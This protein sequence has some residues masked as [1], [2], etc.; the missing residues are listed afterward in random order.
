MKIK[1]EFTQKELSFLEAIAK[2]PYPKNSYSG[3]MSDDKFIIQWK[4]E[5]DTFTKADLFRPVNNGPDTY[6]CN[7]LNERGLEIQKQCELKGY[8]EIEI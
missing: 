6:W 2:K 1:F 7:T 8:A 4:T 5:I 3:R